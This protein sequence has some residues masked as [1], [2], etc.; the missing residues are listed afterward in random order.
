[1]SLQPTL[2]S[3]LS[4]DEQRAITTLVR[5]LDSFTM[6]N[7]EANAYYE[8]KRKLRYG[9]FTIPSD[10]ANRLMPVVGA[11]GTVVDVLDERLDFLGWD[12]V[13]GYDLALGSIFDHNE[14]DSEGPMVHL[15][16]LICGTAFARVGS[17]D[18]SPLVTMHSPFM[19]TGVRDPVTRR[20]RSAWT[21]IDVKDG[22]A[23]RGVLDLPNESITVS[24]AAG[25]WVV[26]DRDEHFLGRVPVVQFTN[27]PRASRRG[28][29][30][31]ITPAIRSLTEAMVRAML[32]MSVNTLF[33]SIPQ[34]MILGRGPEAFKDRN[35][36]PV[37][38]WSILS[39]HALALGRDEEGDIPSVHQLTMASPTPFI[40]Q[41][42]EFRMQ[43][44]AEAGMPADYLG[45]QTSNPPSADAIR[46]TEARLV[47]RAERRQTGFGRSWME[48]ARLATLVAHGSIPSDFNERVST[49]WQS[50]ATPT[51][52]ASADEVT[53]L[54][55][56][57]ILA[58]D[59]EVVMKR[60]GL[61]RSE[62][63]LLRAERART[64][65]RSTVLEALR[66]AGESGASL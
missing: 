44:A 55:G 24:Y 20:L 18:L 26:E 63:R 46:A 52:A 30:S 48:V 14:L 16:A 28:G 57:G 32:G 34:L 15:D 8:A 3:G 21:T 40:E 50:A 29:R 45:I 27:R 17:G 23:V 43:V 1:M 33:Y 54:V 6:A 56:A 2:I 35:G 22:R 25:Q 13:G 31:E 59:S 47:K 19:T 39:G 53:K 61:S 51:R 12:E 38:G 42:R 66:V 4:D 64:D 41:L 7:F 58:P 11:P 10:V 49:D 65:G 37:S 62:E 60:L 5:Q 9:G 36:N